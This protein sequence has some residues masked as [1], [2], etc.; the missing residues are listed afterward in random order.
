MQKRYEQAYS[1]PPRGVDKFFM[2]LPQIIAAFLVCL[3]FPCGSMAADG[4]LKNANAYF[5][6]ILNKLCTIGTCERRPDPNV[7]HEA[8]DILFNSLCLANIDNSDKLN[9]YNESLRKMKVEGGWIIP[10]ALVDK[11]VC[12][13]YGYTIAKHEN[14]AKLAQEKMF[15]NGFYFLGAGDPSGPDLSVTKVEP[16]KN[17]LILVTGVNEMEPGGPFTAYFTK[18]NCGGREHWVFYSLRYKSNPEEND[19]FTIQTDE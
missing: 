6:T 9:A 4:Q 2:R 18:S 7:P 17:G 16:M 3:L 5:E 10:Q 14:L 12:K 1:R 15:T 8:K 19:D 11:A 13:Y